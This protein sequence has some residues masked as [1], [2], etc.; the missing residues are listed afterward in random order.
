MPCGRPRRSG[1][2]PGEDAGMQESGRK[3]QGRW[4][5]ER[6]PAVPCGRPRRSEV[7]LGEDA[8]MRESGRKSLGGV[9]REQEPEG[10][11]E[12]QRGERGRVWK[13]SWWEGVCVSLSAGGRETSGG[14]QAG[15]RGQQAPL[16]RA[17]S[18]LRP[19]ALS[20]LAWDGA[21]RQSPRPA[22][23][24]GVG[25]RSGGIVVKRPRARAAQGAQAGNTGGIRCWKQAESK[26]STCKPG[27]TC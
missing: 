23:E 11:G 24:W 20:A 13:A 14:Y 3:S 17:S 10:A 6:S 15:Q 4:G 1:A 2:G 26:G 18:W 9:G 8:G 25:D 22:D 19:V 7:G 16:E 12:S 21:C 27:G 5:Q